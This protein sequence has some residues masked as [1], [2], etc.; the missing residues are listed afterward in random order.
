MMN[1]YPWN[2]N[3]SYIYQV[4]IE[5]QMNIVLLVFGLRDHPRQATSRVRG[6]SLLKFQNCIFSF[7]CMGAILGWPM[8]WQITMIY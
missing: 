7:Y 8:L 5:T 4:L 1:N 6:V 2:S 3:Q